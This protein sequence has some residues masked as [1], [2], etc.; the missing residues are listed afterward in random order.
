MWMQLSTFKL[1]QGDKQGGKLPF[2]VFVNLFQQQQWRHFCSQKERKH[3]AL[4]SGF[5]ISKKDFLK[6]DSY[7]DIAVLV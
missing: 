1:F 6:V 3:W 2:N 5:V 4:G 7:I